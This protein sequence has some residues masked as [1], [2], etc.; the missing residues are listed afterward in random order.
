MSLGLSRSPG[1]W[2]VVDS[3]DEAAQSA[4]GDMVRTIVRSELLPL[5]S[6]LSLAPTA[7]SR[8]RA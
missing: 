7:Q 1:Y 8:S 3:F 6:N 4:I 2:G 5:R